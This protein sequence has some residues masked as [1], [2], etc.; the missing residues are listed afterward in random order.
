MARRLRFLEPNGIYH[1]NTGGVN[2]G[3]VFV[4]REDRLRFLTLLERVVRRLGWLCQEYC[5]LTTHFHLVVQ[6]PEP[7]LS[8]GMHWL[9]G[10]YA[11]SFNRRHERE[12]HLFGDRFHAVQVLND[13]HLLEVTRYVARNPI[14]AGLCRKPSE[15][16]WSSYGA[17]IG[18]RAPLAFMDYDGVLRRFGQRRGAAIRAVRAFVEEP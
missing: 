6:T 1:V 18:H 14:R 13:G 12:G 8:R 3:A 2:R 5:L 16:E 17:M 11:Q 10:V 15:W 7:N 9:N 4:T